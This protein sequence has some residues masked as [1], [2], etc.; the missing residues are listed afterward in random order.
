MVQLPLM[1]HNPREAPGIGLAIS[2]HLLFD[3]KCLQVAAVSDV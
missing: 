3:T 2:K 1:R